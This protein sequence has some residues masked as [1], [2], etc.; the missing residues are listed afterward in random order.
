MYS[1]RL[2]LTTRVAFGF[3][4]ALLMLA[5]VSGVSYWNILRFSENSHGVTR[6]YEVLAEVHHFRSALSLTS[7]ASR[8]FLLEPSE[9]F[10]RQF[11]QNKGEVTSS[12]AHLREL[13]IENPHQQ[14]RLNILDP[15]MLERLASFD[16]IM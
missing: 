10:Q 13:T 3:A 9:R 8:G 5:L 15:L 7:A 2:G 14:A 12:F 4:I 6:T 11:D 16:E 1:M